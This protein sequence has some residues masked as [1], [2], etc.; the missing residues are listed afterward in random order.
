MVIARKIAYNILFN[1]FAKTIATALALIGIGFIT[2]Y[3]GK[4]G[5]GNYATVIAFF[6]FFT[7]LADL[8]M[9][10]VATREISRPD[11]DEKK[12]ISNVFSLRVIT[13][14][15]IFFLSP[16]IIFL[17]PYD[18]EVKKG[19]L[20]AVAAFVFSSSYM[21]LNGVFQKHLA[22]DKVAVAELIGKAVQVAMV[23]AA[24]KYNLGFSIVIFSILIGIIVNFLL[25]F[26][27]SRKYIK[28][29]FHLDFSYWKHFL[30]GSLPVGIAVM[31]TF[32]YFKADTILL[33]VL[34]SSADV[35]V[36]NAAYKIIENI[37]YL[38]GLIIGLVLP[39]MSLNIF[40][41]RKKF[42]DISNKTF[43]LFFLL[44]VPLV[45]GT[46]FLAKEI[47]DIIG[48]IGFNES[49]AVLRILI[50]ALAF[51]FFGN[52]F[53]TILIAGNL[54][55]RLMIVLSFCALFNITANLAIIPRLSYIGAAFTSVATELLV[56]ALTSFVVARKLKYKPKFEH[57]G[58]II[59]AGLV[60][61]GFLL[62]FKEHSFFI[63]A[64][65]GVGIYALM[66]WL[67]K[68]VTSQEILSIVSRKGY[69]QP[70]EIIQ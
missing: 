65:L 1:V 45:T 3:L 27:F 59:M 14:L 46:I 19:I 23:I 66:L 40:S 7:A 13:S 37:S 18:P 24:V 48:G 34:K 10:T 31:V 35:G 50:F 69:V 6:S 29:G 47:I 12:I 16:L 4:E 56:V 60:M 70:E 54:Q 57:G 61:G 20:V 58:R 32:L 26:L 49:V 38:P 64:F 8:G 15:L 39:L 22:M 36:Y 62:L 17:L 68:T 41:N 2:R 11:S 33:S 55:K 53:N 30:K 51:I 25:V 5:F 52:F 21:V 63:R 9:Y 28:F 42:E 44:V 43:K 67:T